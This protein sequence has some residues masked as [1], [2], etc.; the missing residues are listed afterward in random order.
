M[1]A[2]G[3]FVTGG[4]GF[5][6]SAVAR[7]LLAAGTRVAVLTRN[8]PELPPEIAGRVEA[9]TGDFSAHEAIAGALAHCHTVVHC[10]KSDDP[11]L[12]RRHTSD[13]DGT[14]ALLASARAAGV[15][16]FV[17]LSTISVYPTQPSGFI[18]ES[19]PYG[20]STDE[21]ATGKRQCEDAVLARRADFEVIVLQ[22]ANVYGPGWNW[23]RQELLDLMRKGRVILV[24]GGD[25]IANMVHVDDVA[26]A[27]E[28]AV[29][30]RGVPGNRYLLTDGHPRPWSEYFAALERVVGHP[31]TASMSVDEAKRYSRGIR[32]AS[33][34]S[35]VTTA[36]ARRLLRQRP[37]FEMEDDAIDRFASQAV[38]VIDRARREL[39]YEPR[40][41][42]TT[43]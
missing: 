6:G 22:P 19:A 34:F 30:G 25:G 29:S 32:Q 27:V 17:H 35:H 4:R 16:R 10:A 40:V 11:D 7:R 28:L 26:A 39:G 5:V 2:D 33:A 13:V 20:Q 36:I 31:A 21:Y 9:V 3:V 12:R 18:D 24:N 8:P 43:L 42:E 14:S 15:R 38:F 23:W 1:P 41:T 37:I